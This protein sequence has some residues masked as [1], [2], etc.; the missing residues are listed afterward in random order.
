MDKNKCTAWITG[1]VMH[2]YGKVLGTTYQYVKNKSNYKRKTTSFHARTNEIEKYKC[3]LIHV[4][5][6]L[7]ERSKR[8]EPKVTITNVKNGS[9]K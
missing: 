6:G 3:F 8:F 4:G 2:I 5:Y 1:V 9:Q 7:Q